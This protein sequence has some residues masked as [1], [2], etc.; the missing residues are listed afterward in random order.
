M[1]GKP[2]RIMYNSQFLADEG[3]ASSHPPMLRAS[4]C[5]TN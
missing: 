3:R 2:A 4:S 5:P 1:M